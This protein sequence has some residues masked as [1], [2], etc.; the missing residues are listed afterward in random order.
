MKDFLSEIRFPYRVITLPKIKQMSK[1]LKSFM[2]SLAFILLYFYATAG[3]VKLFW[4]TKNKYMFS[5]RV[6]ILV[7]LH[8]LV[9]LIAVILPY[10]LFGASNTDTIY[11]IKIVNHSLYILLGLITK[12]LIKN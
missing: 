1:D 2:W 12:T 8:V 7:Y 5:G 9:T 11:K 3:I 10:N 6:K 4:N